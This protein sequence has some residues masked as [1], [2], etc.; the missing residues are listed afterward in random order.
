MLSDLGQHITSQTSPGKT[1]TKNVDKTRSRASNPDQL[2]DLSKD[3]KIPEL[4][5]EIEEW[6]PRESNPQPTDYDYTFLP[7]TN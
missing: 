2:E 4:S 6:A 1:L 7:S 5:S 3:E